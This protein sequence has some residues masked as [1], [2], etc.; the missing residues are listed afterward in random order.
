MV[1]K[2]NLQNNLKLFKQ[3][4]YFDTRK[5]INPTVEYLNTCVN[6]LENLSHSKYKI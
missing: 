3:F 2:I 5:L 4:I 6:S 1:R